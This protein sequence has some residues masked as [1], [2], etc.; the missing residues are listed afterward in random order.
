MT[1]F[2]K[3]TREANFLSLAG[4]VVMSFFG[5]AGFA[6]LARRFPMDVFGE[7]VLYIAGSALVDMFRFG[8]VNTAIVRYLSGADAE[9]RPR[10]IGSFI[11]LVII[12]TAGIA[13]IMTGCRLLFP[14]AIASAGY[15]LFFTWY[16]I[17]SFV[18]IPF[19][20]ATVIMQ[21][22]Q[23]FDRILLVNGLFGLAFFSV[24]LAN[25]LFLH[26]TLTQI[27]LAQI[28]ISFVFSV[29]CMALGVDGSRNLFKA[30]RRTNRTILDFGKYTTLTLIGTNLLRSADTLIIS[31]SPLG[32]AA[33]A[34]YSIPMKIT[35]LQQIPLRSFVATAFPRMS[36]ASM[37]GM[38]QEVK[39]LFYTYAGA[40]TLLFAV[41][42][43]GIFFFADFLVLT[44]GGVKYLGTDPV[45]GANAT[46]LVRIFALYGLL[47]PIERM[48]GIGLDSINQPGRNFQ[49]VVYM[50]IA[51]VIGDLVAVFLFKSLAAVAIASIVFTALGIWIGFYFLNRDLGL[52]QRKI[53]SS[54]IEFYRQ[55]IY[56]FRKPAQQL[57]D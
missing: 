38:K 6:L 39:S 35:E 40:M 49:K 28:A 13:I 2:G 43:L 16:P 17:V 33:V 30:T 22:D 42:S 1:A 29:V 55:M 48:T 5:F 12:A 10:F 47:L 24:I 50:V 31:L 32:T 52:K 11:L 41:M 36:K 3:L 51:N 15:G 20:T 19:F 37:L 18:N 26:L 9:E 8:I 44:L 21:A 23:R 46:L 53:F 45:T 56:K 57:I 7:W 25:F 4:N 34:L 54:G 14:Q 27:V